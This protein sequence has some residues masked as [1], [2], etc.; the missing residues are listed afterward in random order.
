MYI[1]DV[2][3]LTF[4]DADI[5]IFTWFLIKMRAIIYISLGFFITIVATYTHTIHKQIARLFAFPPSHILRTL[6]RI[7]GRKIS[8]I[9]TYLEHF[10]SKYSTQWLLCISNNS[11]SSF[12]TVR[13]LHPF[14][15]NS[16]IVLVEEL[17]CADLGG[18]A[19]P[20]RLFTSRHES[21]R[22]FFLLHSLLS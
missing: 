1:S 7:W 16:P 2:I 8:W 21:W 15:E 12:H 9:H 22:L 5:Y 6:F 3:I 19:N 20:F 4:I 17:P 13:K 14:D 10:S 18:F 11:R